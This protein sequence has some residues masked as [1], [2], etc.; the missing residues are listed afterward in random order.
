MSMRRASLRRGLTAA[1]LSGSLVV[2]GGT[3][4]WAD[5][6]APDTT[7]PTIVSTGMTEGQFAP[8]VFLFTPTVTDDVR[9]SSVL[10]LIRGYIQG[11]CQLRTDGL[12]QCRAVLTSAIVP[13]ETPIDI[14]L[15]ASDASG[16]KTEATTRVR[17]NNTPP[18]GA[19][20]PVRGTSMH[21]GTVAITLTDVSSDVVRVVSSEGAELTAAP[22]SF[23]WQAVNRAKSP[24]FDL[25]D[26][27]GN[28]TTL[29]TGYIVDDDAPVIQS[30]VSLAT[31]MDTVLDGGAGWV[32]DAGTLTAAVQDASP[33][34]YEWWVD[35]ALKS[36]GQYFYWRT[37]GMTARTA[38]VELKVW[39]AVGN[40]ASRSY[41]VNIDNKPP[42]LGSIT[43]AHHALIRGSRFTT[44]IRVSDPNGLAYSNLQGADY[45]NVEPGKFTTVSLASGR[46]GTR[47]FTWLVIDRLGNYTTYSRDVIVD[48]TLPTLRL[49]KAPRNKSML[50]TTTRIAAAAGDRNGVARIQLLVNGKVVATASRTA[51]SFALNPK[52]YGKTFTV[53]LRA[54]DRAGNVRYTGKLTYRR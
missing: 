40:S 10:V 17:A 35:G 38:N 18:T 32:G 31:Y 39:D 43:P 27:A 14:T 47:R 16:N 15:R 12:W 5:A 49:T 29:A 53:Q 54:Y 3:P 48:N 13:D 52:K 9:V 6:D 36:T 21:S 7:P 1:V 51:Y 19:V 28:K 50:K 45:R 23:P 46:D 22:W 37:T 33:L 26:Q 2:A 20:S 24:S 42:A 34:R 8:A 44:T 25:Y 11:G 41:V 30:A 4:A